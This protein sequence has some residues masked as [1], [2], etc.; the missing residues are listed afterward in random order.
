MNWLLLAEVAGAA[1][2]AGL[3]SYLFQRGI[4]MDRLKTVVSEVV[5]E[6]LHGVNGRLEKLEGR[7]TTLER[8]AA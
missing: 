1:V 7:V 4:G 3:G 8:K 5:R 6:E 2:G